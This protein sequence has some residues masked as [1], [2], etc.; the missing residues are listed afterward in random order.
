MVAAKKGSGIGRIQRWLLGMIAAGITDRAELAKLSRRPPGTI[1]KALLALSWRGALDVAGTSITDKGRHIVATMPLAD[2]AM[3]DMH[4][5]ERQILR[6]LRRL[7]SIRSAELAERL[8]MTRQSVYCYTGHLIYLDLI[9]RR[10]AGRP[11]AT[12]RHGYV[13]ELTEDGHEWVAD[14]RSSRWNR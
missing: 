10:L 4:V 8:G 11:G 12:G 13:Y 6:V 3:H 7:E 2:I 14:D 9:K 5:R 1:N